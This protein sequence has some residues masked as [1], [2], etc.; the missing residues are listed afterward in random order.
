MSETVSG[1]RYKLANGTLVD[2]NGKPLEEAKIK[3]EPVAVK[4]AEPVATKPV[5]ETKP[6]TE[7]EKAALKKAEKEA[8]SHR[9]LP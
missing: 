1:G 8:A 7:A 9:T 5:A 2:A 4:V 6:L 3:A